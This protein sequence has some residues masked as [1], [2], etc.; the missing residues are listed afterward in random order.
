MQTLAGGSPEVQASMQRLVDS[1]LQ[2][3]RNWD[4]SQT[5]LQQ[6]EQS[7]KVRQYLTL[8][9]PANGAARRAADGRL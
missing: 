8:R 3:L 2:R 7:G 6:L 4:I 5:E 1:A 9:S